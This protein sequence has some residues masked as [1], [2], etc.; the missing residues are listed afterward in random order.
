MIYNNIEFHNVAELETADGLP[1]LSLQRF[2]KQ[3]RHELGHG[4]H[5]RGRFYSQ[6]SAGCEIRFVT[7]AKF[8]KISLSSREKVGSVIVYKGDFL[9]SV[10]T[11]PAGII[12]TLHLE[13]PPKFSGLDPDLLHSKGFSANVWRFVFGKDS[14]VNFHNL[15]TFGNSCRPPL[16]EEKP[17]LTWLAYGSSI[18]FGGDTN[19]YSNAY[20]P[21]AARRLN[22]DV[23]NKGIAGSCFC[24]PAMADYL[25]TLNFDVVTL[26][27]GVNMRG[28]FNGAEYESRVN[29]LLGKLRSKSANKPIFVLGVFPNGSNMALNPDRFGQNDLLFS[30]ISE[31]IVK[32]SNDRNLYYIPGDA[33]LTNSSDLSCDLLHPSDDGHIRMGEALAQRIKEILQ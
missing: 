11:L 26:E 13:E 25:A 23:L 16:P 33:V 31:R 17:Q 28:R 27:L 18:T 6:V 1:G 24:D 29:D 22:F 15:D 5:E 21:Q 30:Q 2:P 3:V 8:V 19:L 14:N 12:T 10:H 20:I 32:Q 7:T 9:H 4:D